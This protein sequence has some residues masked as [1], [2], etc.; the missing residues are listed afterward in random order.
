M[1]RLGKL[2]TFLFFA[3]PVRLRLLC[4]ITLVLSFHI[5]GKVSLK[6]LKWTSH[7]SRFIVTF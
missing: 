7:C 5:V 1:Q 2:R 6:M 3:N 4:Y